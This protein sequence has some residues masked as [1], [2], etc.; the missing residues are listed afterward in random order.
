MENYE[1]NYFEA[2]T[3]IKRYEELNKKDKEWLPRLH[4]NRNIEQ[5][6][7]NIEFRQK[8]IDKY[9]AKLP[10]LKEEFKKNKIAELTAE[11]EKIK[12]L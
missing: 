6:K 7:L 8:M 9:T 10:Q 4:N 12:N 1:L 11:I 5:A 3:L 2:L